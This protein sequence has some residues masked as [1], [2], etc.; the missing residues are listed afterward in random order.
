MRSQCN[1]LLRIGFGRER[2]VCVH[3]LVASFTP[4]TFC[5]P[6]FSHGCCTSQVSR[7]HRHHISFCF[8]DGSSTEIQTSRRTVTSTCCAE[9]D[10]VEQLCGSSNPMWTLL[11][12]LIRKT[13]LLAR[14]QRQRGSANLHTCLCVHG[15]TCRV[16]LSRA[17]RH[18]AP[19][20]VS[21]ENITWNDMPGSNFRAVSAARNIEARSTKVE[22]VT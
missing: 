18:L 11:P 4:R 8:A 6:F 5:Q 17:T 3:R 21:S 9:S 14:F 15:R 2:P 10:F 22:S 1:C 7:L 16:Q 19:D 20:G 13:T 12:Q